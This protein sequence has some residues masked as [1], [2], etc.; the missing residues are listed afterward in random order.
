M[1]DELKYKLW[2]YEVEPPAG[3]WN[4]ISSELKES[5]ELLVFSQKLYDYE[6]PPPVLAWNLIA[7]ALAD[8]GTDKNIIPAGRIGA[9]IFKFM[10]A[11]VLIGSS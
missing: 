8:P 2:N 11:A 7:T 3:A 1:S 10:A 6:V 5:K 9:P 4:M